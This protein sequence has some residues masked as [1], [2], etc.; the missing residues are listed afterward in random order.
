MEFSE[1]IG[2]IP[3]GRLSISEALSQLDAVKQGFKA[4]EN[5]KQSLDR[6]QLEMSSIKNSI[7][8]MVSMSY[9]NTRLNEIF[10]KID[11]SIQS[12]FDDFSSIYFSQ[13]NSKISVENIETYLNK[14]VGWVPFNTLNQTVG[15]LQTRFEKHLYSEFEGFK[16]KVKLELANK[17][18]ESR[19]LDITNEDFSQL[20]TRV[21]GIE[22]KLEEM[23]ME[24]DGLQDDEDYDSQ[25][26]MDNMMEDI[27][28][29]AKRE[30]IDEGETE[31]NQSTSPEILTDPTPFKSEANLNTE[32]ASIDPVAFNEPEK[33]T[34]NL[35]LEIDKPN[36]RN[37]RAR[38]SSIGGESKAMQRRGSKESSIAASRGIGGPGGL[39]QINRKITGLQKEIDN[40]KLD[41]E[42][43]KKYSEKLEEEILK[44]KNYT[45]SLENKVKDMFKTLD[46]M[47][48]SFIRALRR[49]GID[50]KIKPK[51]LAVHIPHK[52]LENLEKSIEDKFKR[53][54]TL[55]TSLDKVNADTS[56]LKKFYKEKINEIISSL[57]N[58]DDFQTMVE[59]Q[60]KEI[61]EKIALA[62][63]NYKKHY[64][65][66]NS[67]LF[68]L[69]NPLTSLIFDQ[70]KEN[71]SLSEE[72]GRNQ[73]LFRAMVE[74]Y[75][76]KSD[77]RT[78][79]DQ[80]VFIDHANTLA[81]SRRKRERNKSFTP[82]LYPKTKFYKTN[83]AYKNSSP[84]TDLKS[85]LLLSDSRTIS[86]P[87]VP[88]KEKLVYH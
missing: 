54:I 30:D 75:S 53:L 67:K 41:L 78:R 33:R 38:G 87:K 83:Y 2:N 50:K 72:L 42:E 20:K 80:E 16:T 82:D 39:K 1:Q 81:E 47:E 45:E 15:S 26:E 29:V 66:F 9:F 65:A 61:S 62:Q 23:F 17:A 71:K 49:N 64:E 37:S 70:Q 19:G 24:E 88:G 4:T 13:L 35:K 74:E 14:K 44:S 18:T 56:Q 73:E 63:E 48:A 69:S 28:L 52:G 6:S 58:F 5:I 68:E 43:N 46:V 31:D 85:P 40:Y 55:E 84:K 36:S 3:K 51:E 57:K 8:Q 27:D 10:D 34:E 11:K 59:T 32:T 86:L 76:N 21:T 22:Q 12:K 79:S 25:E 7:T 60:I 77:R